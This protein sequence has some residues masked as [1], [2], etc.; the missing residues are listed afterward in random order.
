M[1]LI[2]V[3]CFLTITCLAWAGEAPK[4]KCTD[5][6]TSIVTQ[7]KGS[8]CQG[9]QKGEKKKILIHQETIERKENPAVTPTKT[10]LPF[11]NKK[12]PKQQPRADKLKSRTRYGGRS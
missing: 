8:L 3:L 11:L 4:C 10:K 6:V 2:T 12:D 7:L 1:K 5:K 9:H